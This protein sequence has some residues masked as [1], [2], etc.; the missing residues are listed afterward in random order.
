VDWSA[1]FSS[2]FS[3]IRVKIACK[4]ASKIPRKR[5]FEFQK[6]LYLIQFKV[7][8]EAGDVGGNANPNDGDNDN[9]DYGFDEDVEEDEFDQDPD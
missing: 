9:N 7:K 8:G 5:L 4:D 6:K 2:F 1:L 3:M